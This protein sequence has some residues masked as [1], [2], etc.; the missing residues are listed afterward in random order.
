MSF[1][2]QIEHEIQFEIPQ[3]YNATGLEKFNKNAE[4]E[5]GGFISSVT[6]NG[7]LITIKTTKSYNNYYEPNSNWNK[8]I[9]FLEDAF[10]FTQEKIF[11]EK[12]LVHDLFKKETL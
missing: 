2:R 11:I 6:Q 5:T 4:N 12:E 1:P 7:N 9:D 8:M 10:Q 3:G